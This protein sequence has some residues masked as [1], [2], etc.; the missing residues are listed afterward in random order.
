MPQVMYR[1][2]ALDCEYIID[3]TG[4]A[5]NIAI[6]Y[7]CL[8]FFLGRL[9]A[10]CLAQIRHDILKHNYK[11]IDWKKKLLLAGYMAEVERAIKYISWLN[12][13][14]RTESGIS[15]CGFDNTNRN[16]YCP[17]HMC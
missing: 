10:K 1:N 17:N 2:I 6:S 8:Y 5:F 12:A 14:T 16:S 3:G 13:I 7:H 15:E 9:E 4:S 11:V